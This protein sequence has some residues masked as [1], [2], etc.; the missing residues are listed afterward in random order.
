MITINNNSSHISGS[1]DGKSYSVSYSKEAYEKLK[2]YADKANSSDNRN[3]YNAYATTFKTAIKK[4]NEQV[5]EEEKVV[6]GTTNLSLKEVPNLNHEIQHYLYNGT[7]CSKFYVPDEIVER[8]KE[9]ESKQISATPFYKFFARLLRNPV[10]TQDKINRI[11]KYICKTWV[12]NDIVDELVANGIN[13]EEAIK[14]ATVYQVGITQEG[15]LVTYKVSQ[16]IGET[17]SLYHQDTED[18]EEVDDIDYEDDQSV[19]VAVDISEFIYQPVRNKKGHFWKKGSDEYNQE[20]NRQL[21]AFKATLPT[22]VIPSEKVSTYNPDQPEVKAVAEYKFA[23]DYTF[24]PPYQGNHG[25]SFYCG[26]EL[27][28]IIKVGKVH[29]LPLWEQVNTD[30]N[31]SGVKG[32]HVGGLDYI[33]GIHENNNGRIVHNIFVSP[34]HIGAVVNVEYGDGAMRVKQY[35]VHSSF[36]GPNN[37][38]YH[39]STYATQ[40]DVEWDLALSSALF[41]I[42]ETEHQVALLR[43]KVQV[44][45]E[46]IDNAF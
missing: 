2:M 34:E 20:R 3:S 18:G 43:E 38:L 12:D 46:L 33:N 44:A 45:Q 7:Q 13:R 19:E 1:I 37:G 15:L 31:K 29:Y 25:D 17:T 6:V 41:T 24:E 16:L 35:F 30:D 39:S 40:T 21:D 5:K 28:H 22:S 26:E 14:Q 27:G 8:I 11:A 36:I 32:L 10:I 23:E 4:L 9:S 42:E